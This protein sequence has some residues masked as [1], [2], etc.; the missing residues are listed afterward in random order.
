MPD[1]RREHLDGCWDAIRRYPDIQYEDW[2]VIIYRELGYN[3]CLRFAPSFCVVCFELG[4]RDIAY[5]PYLRGGT[6]GHRAVIKMC[7]GGLTGM[8]PEERRQ[9]RDLI[10]RSNQQDLLGLL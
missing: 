6:C 9:L 1:L 5:M 7:S 3:A 10:E 2:A 8:L 4:P